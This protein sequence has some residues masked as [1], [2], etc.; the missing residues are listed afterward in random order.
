MNLAVEEAIAKSTLQE[1]ILN[2]L[3]LWRNTDCAIIGRFQCAKL[4]VDLEACHRLGIEIIRRFTGGGAVYHDSGNLNYSLRVSKDSLDWITSQNDFYDFFLRAAIKALSR[5]GISEISTNSGR[6]IWVRGMKLS[7]IAGYT[8]RDFYFGHGT[9]LV[10]SD[11]DKL[12]RIL[13]VSS[14]EGIK[15]SVRSNPSAVTNLSD[16]TDSYLSLDTVKEALV[17]GFEEVFGADFVG[18]RLYDE[19]RRLSMVLYRERYLEEPCSPHCPLTKY[20][21]CSVCPYH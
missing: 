8:S 2:T 16:L 11:L 10:D 13:T 14:R 17:C 4:E 15:T 3:R 19:E 5:L 1:S 7:G 21:S 6:G 18:G 12:R 9:L 20:I